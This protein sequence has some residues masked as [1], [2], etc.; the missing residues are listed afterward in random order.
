M[1]SLEVTC[2]TM[3]SLE[4][5]CDTIMSLE[6]TCDTMMSLEL[7]CNCRVPRATPIDVMPHSGHILVTSFL[8]P[9]TGMTWAKLQNDGNGMLVVWA[10]FAIQGVWL[11]YC[12]WYF[13]QVGTCVADWN[14]KNYATVEFE[15]GP[16]VWQLNLMVQ[17][18]REA[19]D[20]E[21]H[22]RLVHR[23]RHWVEGC[24]RRGGG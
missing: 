20:V 16:A 19:R 6:L 4:L 8:T 24:G 13:E 10:I 1:M 7:T 2:D 17:L 5:T 9:V 22:S 21:R 14:T 12:A 11:Q 18:E 23:V 3:M 15:K